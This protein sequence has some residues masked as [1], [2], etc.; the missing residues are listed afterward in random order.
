MEPSDKELGASRR[1]LLKTSALGVGA[2]GAMSMV[3]AATSPAGAAGA[4]A[5]AGGVT[6]A[7]LKIDG[8]PGDSRDSKHRDEIEVL[9]F[10]W[11]VSKEAKKTDLQDFAFTISTSKASPLLMLASA[12]GTPIGKAMLTVRSAGAE[13]QEFYKVTLEDCLVSSYQSS[14]SSEIP[15]DQVSLEFGRVTFSY[16]GQRPDGSLD[17]PVEVT[18]P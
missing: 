16:R 5:A 6:D 11:G 1:N 2:L 13:Q 10:A 18:F 12:A 3:G 4:P 7:F 17:T 15:T 9:A 14:S 8:I